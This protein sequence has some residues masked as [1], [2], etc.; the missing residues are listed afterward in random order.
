MPNDEHLPVEQHPKPEIRRPKEIRNPKSTNL[1]TQ[2][3]RV[4][5]F[6]ILSSFG[7]R[8]SS[9]LRLPNS[10][11]DAE[12]PT[13]P[14]RSVRRENFRTAWRKSPRSDIAASVTS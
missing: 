5:D 2:V 12:K 4:L 13:S 14:C 3:F 1:R 7:I 11:A 9:F 10:S 8:H 6:V